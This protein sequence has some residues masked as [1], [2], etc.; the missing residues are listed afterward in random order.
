MT[1][2]EERALAEKEYRNLFNDYEKQFFAPDGDFVIPE[3]FFENGNKLKVAVHDG[4][5]HG[6]DLACVAV[7]SWLVGT[8]RFELVRTRDPEVL[9]HCLRIDVGEGLLDHHGARAC[10][11]ECA[12]TRL[13]GTLTTAINWS[14]YIQDQLRLWAEPIMLVDTGEWSADAL[15]LES[16]LAKVFCK[17]EDPDFDRGFAKA[18]AIVED[19]FAR[20]MENWRA[21][22]RARTVAIN[23]IQDQRGEPVIVFDT[24]ATKAPVKKLIWNFSKDTV[25]Y[26]SPAGSSD[27]RVLCCADPDEA[28]SGFSSWRLI[29][30]KYRSLRGE[31]FIRETGIEDAIFCHAA[32]FIAGFKTQAS[33]K[34]FAELCLDNILNEEED[35]E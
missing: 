24:A 21:E 13:L 30:E 16:D 15:P 22:E 9:K 2:E 17:S 25:F 8:D 27:W 34:A 7:I 23:N 32:G 29:P 11:G 33:A 31:D 1:E 26:V 28:F 3:G 12:L 20:R 35:K 18:L 5:F 14:S 10:E 19:V 4:Y 6:D